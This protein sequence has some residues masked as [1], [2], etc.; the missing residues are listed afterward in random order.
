MSWN[1]SLDVLDSAQQTWI[2]RKHG[3]ISRG[4]STNL[5]N[6]NYEKLI[7]KK[8]KKKLK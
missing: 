4:K 1:K 3:R 2:S 7:L 5:E 6:W 8:K